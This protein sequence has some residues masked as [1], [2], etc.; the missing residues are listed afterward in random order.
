MNSSRYIFLSAGRR[1]WL[2]LACFACWSGFGLQAAGLQVQKMDPPGW[3]TDLQLQKVLLLVQGEELSGATVA[4]SSSR[5]KPKVLQASANGHYLFVELEI[6]RK[7]K[8]GDYVLAFRKGGQEIK[9][10]FHLRKSCKTWHEPAGFTSQ[11]VVYLLMPDRFADGNPAN[12]SQP[13][14]AA[15]AS[16]DEP[17]GWHGGDFAGLEAHLDYFVGLGVSA[18]WMTPVFEN[19]GPISYHGYHITDHYRADPHFGTVEEYAALVR[20]AHAKGLKVIQDQIANH[21][22]PAHPW[23]QDP[24]TPTWFNG[25][26]GEHLSC[27]WNIPGLASPHTPEHGRDLTVRGWFAGIL[28]D[29]NNDDPLQTRYL[30]QNSI[31]WVAMT[32]LDGIRLDTYPYTSYEFW[33]QWLPALRREFPRLSIVGEVMDWKPQ[34]VAYWQKGFPKI[35]GTAEGP[36]SLMDF[37]WMNALRAA[38]TKPEGW[39]QCRDIYQTDFV[40]PIPE[41]SF[42]FLGNHDTNRY[43]TEVG[44]GGAR[45]RTA[46]AVCLLLKGIPQIFYGDE[47]AMAGGSDPD[48][49]HDM[50]GGFAGDA[51]NAFTGAGLSAE[52]AEVQ[53][54]TRRLLEVRKQYAALRSG[55]FTELLVTPETMAI[56]KEAGDSKAL[57]LFHLGPKPGPFELSL[58][59]FRPA[60]DGRYH[61]ALEPARKLEIRGNTAVFELEPNGVQIWIKE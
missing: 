58:P 4:A 21:V 22:G 23:A 30:I 37:P 57:L 33:K 27:D 1:V 26:P 18:V 19:A 31:W 16:R 52:Q 46:L 40:Y 13:S 60:L 7:A 42:V 3:F 44:D 34:T 32:G 14:N 11:D 59:A 61:S 48:N 12:N 20:Q 5:L 56:L 25:S 54:W 43:R 47:L 15:E 9:F 36:E 8:A 29:L 17:R 38:L 53:A 10:P 50:P 28:P 51:G 49:R 24:P 55:C 2:L 39:L 41:Q 35:D 45:F 6:H